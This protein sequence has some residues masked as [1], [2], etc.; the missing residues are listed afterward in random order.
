MDGL[1]IEKPHRPALR[2][3]GGKWMLAP[4]II[5]H[6]P[7]HRIYVEPFGGAA[8][9]LLRKDRSFMEVYND[10]DGE[11]VNLFKVLRDRTKAKR[12][13]DLLR[14][15]PWSRAEF[16]NSYTPSRYPIEQAR[17]TVL[18]SF[19]AFGT[20]VRR[21]YMT[22]FRGKA[23]RKNNTGINDWHNYP[24]SLSKVVNRL[25]GVCIESRPALEIL[26]QQDD[27]ETLFYVDPPY[28]HSTRV[29]VKFDSRKDRCY[30]HEMTDDDHRELSAAL[31]SV[32]GM[33]VLS[34]YHCE[35]YNQELYKDWRSVER[36]GFADGGAKRIE[37]LWL[38]PAAV[39]RL[40]SDRSQGILFA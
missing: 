7:S 24:D 8:S 3:H 26:R 15:T 13:M 1:A 35:L 11:V 30:A 37:V 2:Y 20:T 16:E 32:K 27:E 33:V 25:Q 18:R 23:E 36:T 4:W 29:S 6:F 40:E 17:R 19:M 22:G 10:L 39:S 14:L 21:E 38:N 9:V 12:L 28:P 31:H 5:E 34:G